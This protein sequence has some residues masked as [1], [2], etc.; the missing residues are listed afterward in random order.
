VL[1]GAPLVL[2][3]LELGHPAFMPNDDIFAIVAPIAVWWTALHVAQ[4]PLFALLGLAVFLLVRGLEGRA[5]HLSRAAI[6][7]FVV[8]YP[9]FDAAVGVSS[10]VLLQNLSTLGAEQRAVLQ[11]ALHALFWGPITGLLAIVGSAS[12]LVAL[13]AAAWAWREADAP[14]MAIALLAVSGLLLAVSH[15]RPFGPLACLCF[16]IAAGLV[17]RRSGKVRS[18]SAAPVSR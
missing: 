2:G 4:I 12:W 14:R 18:R 16:L 11:P 7:V 13:L 1:F 3:L 10:G 8:V 5:A 17:E 15:I 6:A 9:A